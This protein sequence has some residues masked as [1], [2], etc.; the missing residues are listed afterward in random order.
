MNFEW[1][2]HKRITN[3]KKHGVD[4]VAASRLW[5]SPMLVVED[6]RSNYQEP[7]WI[8]MGLLEKRMMIIVY[9]K[10]RNT[11]RI[12]SFRKAN[13]REVKYYEKACS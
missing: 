3:L 11:I 9:T 1:D 5:D 2:E 8:G 12:I 4:F 13:K 7:R 6:T 10:R